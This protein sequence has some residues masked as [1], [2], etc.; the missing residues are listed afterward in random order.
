MVKQ[1]YKKTEIGVIPED[2]EVKKINDISKP[3]RGG[4]PRPAGSPLFFNGNYIPW[5]TVASLTN[6]SNS[7]IYVD[8]TES[9]LTELGSNY[10]R[11]LEKDTLIISNS[12]ATLGVA[13]L[14]GIECCANDG[15]AAL[16][17]LKADNKFLV[18]Y[19]N[20]LTEYLRNNVATG[21]GQPNLNTDLIGNLSIPLPPLAEQEA[22]ATALSDADAWIEHLEQLIAKKR[23]F[24]Q[25]AMQELLTPPTEELVLSGVEAWE[26]KKLGEVG[27]TYGGL[28]G[29]TKV[30]FGK[31]N[32]HYI[33]FMNVMKNVVIDNSFFEKVN[34]KQGEIQNKVL[35]NDL[36]FNGSSETPEELGISSVILEDINN[37]Y[38]NS[39]CFGFRLFDNNVNPLFLSY[40]FRSPYGRKII[41]YLAQGATRYNL[42]KANF[43]ELEISIPKSLSEQERI[44]TILSDMGAELEA[45]ATQ[46]GKARQIKQGMM[47]ELLTGRVRLV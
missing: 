13:K 30:D 29:K 22:I 23:L 37:L 34:L 4:S 25:G 40:L 18:Y 17:D 5:L 8:N 11:R 44:A 15:I 26:V 6:I 19:I 45:L 43:L 32:A 24:K 46:L 35:K 41:F 20:S 31:G 12:G 7:K 38:L 14:L 47:Q 16:L 36:L 27:K 39:F 2:W 21:N 10:S 33:P 42:S 1:G 3:V 28:S 9:M